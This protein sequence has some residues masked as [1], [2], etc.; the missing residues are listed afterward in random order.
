M[1]PA[2]AIVDQMVE[3]AVAIL[4]ACASKVCTFPIRVIYTECRFAQDGFLISGM[5]LLQWKFATCFDTRLCAIGE[6][7][8]GVE[9]LKFVRERVER[10][11]SLVQSIYLVNEE[12]W[13]LHVTDVDLKHV[14]CSLSARRHLLRHSSRP[15]ALPGCRRVD[16][17]CPGLMFLQYVGRPVGKSIFLPPCR[18][19]HYIV[20]I[21]EGWTKILRRMISHSSKVENSA[22]ISFYLLR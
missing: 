14:K 13:S 3:Q 11:C 8:E 21:R 5:Y 1:L 22:A 12:T 20:E 2:K 10:K 4:Q 18:T 9:A 6:C 15:G 19:G 16:V 17:F 7:G